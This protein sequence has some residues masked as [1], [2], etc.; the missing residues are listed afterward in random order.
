M[1]TPPLRTYIRLSNITRTIRSHSSA[2][3]R[4]PSSKLGPTVSLDHFLQRSKALS[5]YRRILRDCRRIPDVGSR[6]ET[7]RFVR[8]DFERNRGVTDLVGLVSSCLVGRGVE[9]VS[10]LG[11]LEEYSSM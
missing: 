6:D 5:L 9:S 4:R 8:D 7:R 3:P 2:K 10:R 11:K 1:H